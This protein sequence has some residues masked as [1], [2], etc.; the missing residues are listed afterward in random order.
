M[1]IV[2]MKRKSRRYKA[3]VSGRGS[4]GFSLNG[5]HRNQG[6]VGQGVRGRS[7]GGTRFRGAE[8]MGSGGTN[9]T[10]KRSIVN[11]GRPCTNDPSIIKRSS[12]NTPGLISSRLTPRGAVPL[13]KETLGGKPPIQNVPGSCCTTGPIW[14]QGDAYNA[15]LNSSQSSRIDRIKRKAAT[16]VTLKSDAGL[17]RCG[18]GPDV[19]STTVTQTDC[20]G[21]PRVTVSFDPE[22]RHYVDQE[23]SRGRTPP[24]PLPATVGG[25]VLSKGEKV[26]WLE[27]AG[28][29]KAWDEIIDDEDLVTRAGILLDADI[30]YE[31][32]DEGGGYGAPAARLLVLADFGTGSGGPRWL[33]FVIGIEFRTD[34]AREP[35]R[36]TTALLNLADVHH[37]KPPLPPQSITEGQLFPLCPSQ[38]DNAIL[39]STEG[40]PLV[41]VT[42]VPIT[43]TTAAT[44]HQRCK[45]ASYHIGGKKFVRTMY[46][47]NLN[48]LA[49]DQSQYMYSGLMAKNDLPTPPCKAPFPSVG[50]ANKWCGESYTDPELAKA[51]GML[52]SM[53]WGDCKKCENPGM[54]YTTSPGTSQHVPVQTPL[55]DHTIEQRARLDGQRLRALAPLPSAATQL[56]T[57]FDA[58][59]YLI[60]RILTPGHPLKEACTSPF[61]TASCPGQG[62]WPCTALHK[63]SVCNGVFPPE[64]GASRFGVVY[65]KGFGTHT[66]ADMTMGTCSYVFDSDSDSRCCTGDCS[67]S[68]PQPCCIPTPHNLAGVPPLP[69]GCCATAPSALCAG[70]TWA[71]ADEPN[72]VVNPLAAAKWR[73]GLIASAITAMGTW[74]GPTVVAWIRPSQCGFQYIQNMMAVRDLVWESAKDGWPPKYAADASLEGAYN[75]VDYVGNYDSYHFAIFYARTVAEAKTQF[76]WDDVDPAEIEVIRDS[77]LPVVLMDNVVIANDND[78]NL[79]YLS[80]DLRA[81]A[82]ELKFTDV[83]LPPNQPPPSQLL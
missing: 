72:P 31:R 32:A 42:C 18:Q 80:A 65:K 71:K 34:G 6:W 41:T 21:R 51:A 59:E 27:E 22:L 77:G 11:G 45:A 3:V 7:L 82:R 56:Q 46:S 70:G 48:G 74:P 12:S 53:D 52:L 10:Y 35:G 50:K 57:W 36:L 20:C 2:A 81:A 30:Y 15:G 58:G 79:G 25:R 23:V 76:D 83:P 14:V 16:C 38:P 44:R 9:G 61:R 64:W 55:R 28:V 4:A 37:K 29:E 40:K 62:F 24:P 69:D 33:W 60:V 67:Y 66:V 5:G 13:G 19:G 75:E 39:R 43:T 49:V 73:E 63:D 78:A 1:S 54:M 17:D 47:K 8:P 26:E 68:G